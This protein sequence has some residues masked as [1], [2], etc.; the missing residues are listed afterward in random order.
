[1]LYDQCRGEV[2]IDIKQVDDMLHVNVTDNGIGF[3]G[4]N[5]DRLFEPFK[6]LSQYN[7]REHGGTGLGL[8]IVKKY[9]EMHKGNIW[10]KS[11]P[12]KGSTFAFVITVEPK[13]ECQG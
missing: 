5:T 10:V 1:M 13:I 11:K 9:V 6:Q 4:E 7:I 8:A 3:S 2:S 12:G